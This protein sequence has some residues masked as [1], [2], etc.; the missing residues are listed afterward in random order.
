VIKI[1]E[2]FISYIDILQ[3]FLKNPYLKILL[4]LKENKK[5]TKQNKKPTK[6]KQTNKQ[7]NKQKP[8]QKTCYLT[9]LVSICPGWFC[10][11][12]ETL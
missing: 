8:K 1:Q 10:S 2:E 5:Q 6:Q 11:R 7:T 9:V 3:T 4:S 12:K